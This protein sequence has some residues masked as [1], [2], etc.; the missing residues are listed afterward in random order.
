VPFESQ[1]PRLSIRELVKNS[2]G[3]YLEI[4]SQNEGTWKLDIPYSGSP[5]AALEFED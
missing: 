3:V 2:D 1:A 4:A 5:G